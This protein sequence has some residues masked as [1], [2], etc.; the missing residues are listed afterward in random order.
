M[1]IL[2]LYLT[3]VIKQ[4]EIFTDNAERTKRQPA[5]KETNIFYRNLSYIF[6]LKNKGIYAEKKC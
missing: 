3:C 4:V 5:E 6:L 1:F 2:C